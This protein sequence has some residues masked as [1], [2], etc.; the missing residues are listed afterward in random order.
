MKLTPSTIK[1]LA[2]PP[3][4]RDKT[5][6]DDDLGGFGLR[7]RSGGAA[8]WVVQYD[9]GG[10][11]RRVTLGTTAMLDLGSARAKAKDLLAAVRLGRDPASEK[12]EARVR[13]AETFAALLPR[14]LKHKSGKVR[15]V[16]LKEIERHLGKHAKPLHPRPITAIDRRTVASLIS[17]LTEKNGPTAAK[18]VR[19]SLAA[20]FT[21]LTR[22]GL[23]DANPV[24]FTNVPTTNAVRS[25][26][27]SD[28]EL[29][30]IW[31]VLGDDD[32][33][34]IVRLLIFTGARRL[35]IG[36]LSWDEVDLKAAEI[37]LP[38]TR[39]KNNR[40]HIIPLSAPA[41]TI[42]ARQLRNG[43]PY[44]FGRGQVGFQGWSRGKRSLDARAPEIPGWVLH[45]L[46][47]LVST[48][49][50]DKLGVP[51]HIVEAVLAH[52]GHKSGIAGT[53]NK[54]IYLDERRRALQRWAE[55]IEQVVSGKKPSTVVKLRKRR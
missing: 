19:A 12:Q 25:R 45:D 7:L 47:R 24:A 9:I 39:C 21:W 33:D 1:T 36:N 32:Y 34:D 28:D 26:L 18:C 11:S 46:R 41:L 8:R 53:Y 51:P 40:P 6:F 43:R 37:R 20:Y 52:V 14:Y 50:H 54:A 30:V 15:P 5:F 29:R 22:E 10:K 16:S 48:T 27:L 35:E 31:G 49:M 42:L 55:H 17:A 38:A 2:L 4:A 44:V 3:G 23:L 13:A